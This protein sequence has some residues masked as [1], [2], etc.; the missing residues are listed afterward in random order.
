MLLIY[1]Q[2]ITPRITYAF[3][4]ICTRILGIE[5]GFTSVIEEL[6][7]HSGPKLSYGKQAMGNELF[8]QSEGLLTQQGFESIDITVKD[9]EDTKCFFSTS[10]HC[11]LPF[12]IFAAS[13]YLMSRYE[14]YL[15]HVK[16]EIG[17]YPV[18]ESLAYQEGFLKQ[19]VVD[20]W[21]YKFKEVLHTAFPDL[22]FPLKKTKVH[23]IVEA[24][25]PFAYIQRGFLRTLLGYASDVSKL[26]FRAVIERTR[27]IMRLRKDPYHSFKWIVNKSKKS[28]SKLTVFFLLGDS[29]TFKESM[30]THR[31]AFKMLVKYVADYNETGLIFSFEALKEY[32]I[33]KKEKKRM[34]EITNRSVLSTMNARFLVSLPEIYR[35]LVELEVAKDYTMVYENEV[36]FRAGTC[37]PFL[38]YDLDS[39]IKTPL[40]IQPLAMTTTAFEKKYESDIKKTIANVFRSVEKVNGTFTMLFTNRDF[41]SSEKNKI[42]RSI[43]SE[44][45]QKYDS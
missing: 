16:D 32:E 26:K 35:N 8:L 13:F 1:T 23:T 3:R 43:F 24:S 15:P 44:K 40:I 6:I 41:S 45:L 33:L 21:A 34:E 14:E 11:A 42:W 9:W 18:T 2:K 39:E 36:G 19:P 27:V 28:K 4:H 30:N 10:G 25:Q 7:S 29:L 5:I 38:F 31:L 22:E 37:T 17:R 20:V 12:D